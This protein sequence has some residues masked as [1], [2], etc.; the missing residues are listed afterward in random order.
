M[1]KKKR[2]IGIIIVLIV[3]WGTAG[4][5]NN[6]NISN[7]QPPVIVLEKIEVTTL[8]AQTLFFVGET[9]DLAGLIVIATYSDGSSKPVTGYTTSLANGVFT[10]MNA[11]DELNGNIELINDQT[12]QA[13]A[14]AKQASE[15][16]DNAKQS[17]VS[18]DNEM[19]AL[20]VSMDAIKDAARNI[21]KIVKTIED[22]AFQTNLLALN[23]AVEAARAGEHGRGF[24]VVAEEVRTLAGRS[25]IA[26]KETEGLITEAISSVGKGAENAEKT[27]KT[28]EAIVSD[29]EHV[30]SIVN[31]IA[32]SQAK[33]SE[34]IGL[35]STSVS[36]ISEITHENDASSQQAADAS[37]K[38]ADMAEQLLDLFR[39]RS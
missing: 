27:A 26:S 8:P 23:A 15:L 4:C 13:A 11:I 14:S 37:V 29:F 31:E 30:S 25:Q 19:Q 36:R 32:E 22:I 10:Q 38:L 6:T 34:S 1:K 2:A 16:S 5:N 39:G 3:L 17:A 7:E 33:Q 21:S 20:L 9:L 28:L 24:A 12:K 18:G 35:I